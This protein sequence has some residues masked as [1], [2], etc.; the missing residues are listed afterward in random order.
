MGDRDKKER[1]SVLS[2]ACELDNRS[3]QRTRNYSNNILK[4]VSVSCLSRGFA[5]YGTYL[6]KVLLNRLTDGSGD[7]SN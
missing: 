4:S 3:S 7:R 2:E 1:S 5:A 6:T